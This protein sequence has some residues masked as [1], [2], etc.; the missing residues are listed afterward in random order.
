MASL[1][2][3]L[4]SAGLTLV[5]VSAVGLLWGHLSI[6]FHLAGQAYAGA[7]PADFLPRYAGRLALEILGI[8]VGLG[9]ETPS[10]RLP[11]RDAV[12]LR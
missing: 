5:G 3:R 11:D 7:A 1:R 10:P 6:E 8:T 12:P 9:R 4:T 2:T